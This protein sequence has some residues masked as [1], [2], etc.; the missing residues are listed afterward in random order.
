MCHPAAA[1]SPLGHAHGRE[2][3]D[4][5]QAGAA[6]GASPECWESGCCPVQR[7]GLAASMAPGLQQGLGMGWSGE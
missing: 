3:G 1:Q 2:A 7:L 6:G 5:Y 4:G